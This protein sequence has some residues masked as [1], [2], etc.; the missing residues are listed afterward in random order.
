MQ[1]GRSTRE[2]DRCDEISIMAFRHLFVKTVIES[3]KV[4]KKTTINYQKTGVTERQHPSLFGDRSL[5]N[6]ECIHSAAFLQFVVR[7]FGI[8][9]KDQRMRR[10]V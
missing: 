4:S 3:V 6:L 1:T 8:L 10:P 9:T 7:S 5:L 2:S